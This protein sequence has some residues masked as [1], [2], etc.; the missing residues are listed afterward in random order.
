[1]ET[2]AG[3]L[4]S[5]RRSGLAWLVTGTFASLASHGLVFIVSG[6]TS[7][8]LRG[9]SRLAAQAAVASDR[10]A[11]P[12]NLSAFVV[13]TALSI[14]Y[15][16]P[17]ARFFLKDAGQPAPAKVRR[18][19]LGMPL[20]L[21]VMALVPWI[22]GIVWFVTL[23]VVR[24]RGWAG[25]LAPEQVLAPIVSGFLAATGQYLMLDWITRER[26][27]PLVFPDGNLSTEEPAWTLAVGAR[28]TVL[29]AAIGFTPAFAL[30]GLVT[31]ASERVA[32]GD[33]AVSIVAELRVSA[34][35]LFAFFAVMGAVYAFVFARSLTRPLRSM[36]RAVGDV[37]RGHLDVTVPV[38]S[39]DEIG[40]LS[41]AVNA[42][43]STLGE[44]E[45][46]LRT[47]G[48]I[49]DPHVRDRLLSGGLSAGGEAK[50]V[51]LVFADVRAFTDFAARTDPAG[52]VVALN[53]LFSAMAAEVRS[54]GGFVDKFVGDAM[55]AVFGLF[56][57]DADGAAASAL[58]CG[59]AL[60]RSVAE[61]ALEHRRRDEP[62]LRVAVA[63][64]AG[65]VLAGTIGAEDRFDY[66]VVGDA[67]N[68]ASRLLQVCKEKD[69][70][71]VLSAEALARARR[72]GAV[73]NVQWSGEVQLRGRAQPIV[74]CT[75]APE[76]Q[77]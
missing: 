65:G 14:V 27:V 59:L 18:R 10:F 34:Q 55:L 20:F 37:Q 47:F 25:D 15:L 26:I 28:F 52:V 64:H 31:A 3:H 4:P 33:P 11:A 36:A 57:D 50:T 41:E 40:A 54:A 2:K 21:S 24:L 30:L 44:R 42:L 68:V 16:L 5:R 1:M 72:G 23:T 39:R 61:L 53:S 43:A 62:A 38:R 77:G 32:A 35:Q 58:R 9:T 8:A 12:Y 66:T 45:H 69:C 46:I 60:R 6:L 13:T 48:R 49:V 22:G 76:A 51:A 67:V 29:A 75:V 19:V 73:A 63:V 56:D 70:E 7:P 17:I 74:A 71:L